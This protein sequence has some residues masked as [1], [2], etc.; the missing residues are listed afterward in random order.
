MIRKADVLYVSGMGSS[1]R[2]LD[3]N[4]FNILENAPHMFKDVFKIQYLSS[5]NDD[6]KLPVLII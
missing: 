2:I 6:I 1:N 5:H 4:T 3:N